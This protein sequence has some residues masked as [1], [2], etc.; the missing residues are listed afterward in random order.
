MEAKASSTSQPF[1][2]EFLQS[3]IPLYHTVLL[4]SIALAVIAGAYG[5][6]A[7]LK[8]LHWTEVKKIRSF[9]LLILTIVLVLRRC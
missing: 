1:T 9:D 4:I 2:S 7:L 8:G 6:F 5:I 3:L